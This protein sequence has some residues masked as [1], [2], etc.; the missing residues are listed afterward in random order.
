MT[1]V[2]DPPRHPYVDRALKLAQHWCAGH[3]IDDGPALTHAVAVAK[4]LLDHV[5]DVDPILVAVTLVHDAEEFHDLPEDRL[6]DIVLD[7]GITDGVARLVR[8]L[9]A[10]H[11]AMDAGELPSEHCDLRVV[12]IAAADKVVAFRAL[13]RR[14]HASDD[15]VKFWHERTKLRALLPYFMAWCGRAGPDIPPS[16]LAEVRSAIRVVADEITA[17]GVDLATSHQSNSISYGGRA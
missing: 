3:T 7:N 6:L 11:R 17:S 5:P 12:L 8:E 13:R 16:L 15:P 1:T 10:Q 2:L 4:T 14:A 9:A